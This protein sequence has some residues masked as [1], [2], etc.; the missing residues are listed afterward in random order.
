MK[1]VYQAIAGRIRTELQELARV[2]GR[3]TRIWQQ[4]VVSADDI[5][6]LVLVCRFLAL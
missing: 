6:S 2:A 5:D 4:A 3:A 1:K